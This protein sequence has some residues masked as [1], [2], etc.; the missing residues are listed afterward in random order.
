MKNSTKSVGVESEQTAKPGLSTDEQ[1]KNAVQRS[2]LSDSRILADQV[3]VSSKNGLIEL[4]GTVNSFFEKHT[5]EEIALRLRGVTAVTNK[6]EVVLRVP[7]TRSDRD[8]AIMAASQL[9][10][11]CS[12]PDTVKVSV[13]NGWV[14]F[15]GTVE[16]KYQKDAAEDVLRSIHGVKGILN[17]IVIKPS[18]DVVVLK[19]DIVE[20]F[21]RNAVT[22]SD[23]IKVGVYNGTV[24]L[25]GHVRSWPE[26]EEACRIA[27]TSRGVTDVEDLLT[28]D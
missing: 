14:K 17:E 21:K 20:S 25:N 22:D 12:V 15:E 9:E 23:S 27:W 8:M 3:V 1:L 4:D 6:I 24:T 10:W 28:I 19:E 11:N 18:V 26:R 5:A 7:D 13:S 16:A 2:F